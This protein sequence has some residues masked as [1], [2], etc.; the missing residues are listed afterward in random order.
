MFRFLLFPLLIRKEACTL[1]E[2][3][4]SLLSSTDQT[5]GK[6]HRL[7]RDTQGSAW[8]RWSAP[9][10]LI[11]DLGS[12]SSSC[13]VSSKLQCLLVG[14]DGSPSEQTTSLLHVCYLSVITIRTGVQDSLLLVGKARM[15]RGYVRRWGGSGWRFGF[16]LWFPAVQLVQDWGQL[17]SPLCASLS[18][19]LGVRMLT[20]F[21]QPPDTYRKAVVY[22]R[23][24]FTDTVVRSLNQLLLS[25]TLQ[26]LLFL[27]SDLTIWWP[28][29][30]WAVSS[31]A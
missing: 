16:C 6:S 29:T 17:S 31:E 22:K 14:A 19:P 1:V 21:V 10:D 24:S 28:V 5:V 12:K 8:A 20:T 30:C 2:L 7:M 13:A 23:L 4:K 9:V 3:S 15:S 25:I 26:K 18:P 27:V 11:T